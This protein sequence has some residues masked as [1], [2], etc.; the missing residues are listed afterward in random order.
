MAQ[1]VGYGH[2][3]LE[4]FYAD[5][6]EERS[7]IGNFS[8]LTPPMS[9]HQPH[10]YP[11]LQPDLHQQSFLD[12]ITSSHDPP[13]TLTTTLNSGS[14][15]APSNPMHGITHTDYLDSLTL[16]NPHPPS[17]HPPGCMNKPCC[18]MS[19]LL[20]NNLSIKMMVMRQQRTCPHKTT[21]LPLE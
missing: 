14:A 18:Q 21:F 6:Q 4:E 17:L 12:S 8:L 5:N 2:S 9:H 19:H 13:V 20:S 7:S 3:P 1:P 11:G 10:N 16:L 15:V